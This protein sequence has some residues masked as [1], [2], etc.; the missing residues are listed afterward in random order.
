[1]TEA[2]TLYFSHAKQSLEGLDEAESFV[3]NVAVI[4]RGTLKMSLPVWAANDLIARVLAEYRALYP[5]VL[6][7]LDF[8]G[9][10]VN[11]VE[12]GFDLALRATSAERLDPGLVARPLTNVPFQLVGSPSYLSRAGRP[13]TVDELSS[14]NLLVFSRLVSNETITLIGRNGL[15]FIKCRPVIQS[16]NETMLH[17]AALNG[18]GLA[19]LPSWMT[20]RDVKN[21]RLE[22]VVPDVSNF[23][24][25]LY[26]VYP[27]RKYLSAKVRSFIDFL[28]THRDLCSQT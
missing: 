18:I 24:T 14:H 10:L 15:Q 20:I 22:T 3:S 25:I 13:S 19:L 8:S 7:D 2:G 26:A 23:K 6:F 16:E 28:A 12:E 5:D 11:M 4:P 1:M 9:R 27:S 17:L 21:G